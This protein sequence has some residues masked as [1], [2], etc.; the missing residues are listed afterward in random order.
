MLSNRNGWMSRFKVV[1]VVVCAGMLA[2]ATGG[3]NKEKQLEAEN[4]QLRSEKEGL[5]QANQQLTA[6]NQQLLSEISTNRAPGGPGG[7]TPD[8]A[9]TGRPP[10]GPGGGGDVRLTVAGDVAFSSG[11]AALTSAGKKELDGIASKIKS[12]YSGN[13]IR[14]EGYTDS[15]PIRKSKWG[16]NEALSQARAEA[17]AKY[18]T[19]KGI[20]SSRIDSIG[21][22]AAK[23]KSSKAASRRV[24]IVIMQ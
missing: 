23:P 13:S 17:V 18:L 22:G 9:D 7:F 2:V 14:V 10:R 16:S 5:E 24:E 12:K 20:S 4:T 15:D 1:G 8:Y 3:C 21:M 19:S 11:Q 6:Q